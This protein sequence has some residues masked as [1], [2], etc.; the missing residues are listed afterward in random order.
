[1]GRRHNKIMCSRNVLFQI[2]FQG[3]GDL[4]DFVFQIVSHGKGDYYVIQNVFQEDGDPH[5]INPH[6][7]TWRRPPPRPIPKGPEKF[8][9]G[10][11]KAFF[12]PW[13]NM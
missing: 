1:M 3:D 12:F 7:P 4:F 5:S 8:K 11:Q 9:A 13:G 6:R 10:N 2:I